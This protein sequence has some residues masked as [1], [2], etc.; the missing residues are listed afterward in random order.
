[1]TSKESFENI[2]CEFLEDMEETKSKVSSRTYTKS[3]GI[4]SKK[5]GCTVATTENNCL[6]CTGC[7]RPRA[8]NRHVAGLVN[9]HRFENNTLDTVLKEEEGT[10]TI[11]PASIVL[12][13]YVYEQGQ[14]ASNTLMRRGVGDELKALIPKAFETK[15]CGCQDYARKMNRWGV[16][17]CKKN[18]DEII[19]RLVKK[20]KETKVFGWV[21]DNATRFVAKRLLEMAIAKAEKGSYKSVTETTNKNFEWFVAVTTSPRQECTLR[22]CVESLYL[23]G[24]KPTIFAEPGSTIIKGCQTI[25]NK[26]RKGVWHNWLDSCKYALRNT[27]ADIIMTVQDDSLFHPDSKIFT[28]NILWPDKKTGF[29]SLYTP[30]H[31]SFK[32]KE[33]RKPGVNRIYTRSMWGACALVWPRE[34]LELVVEHPIAKNWLGAPTKSKS[35][36]IK[37]K[38][39]ENPY[40]IQ[41]SDTAIGKI[42]NS[43]KR[44]M[45][46][47]DPSPVQHFSRHSAINHG[48]NLG[49]RNC[50]RCADWETPLAGQ[51]LVDFKPV[52]IKT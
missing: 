50:H 2:N 36:K 3:C 38:R 37:Q 40:M 17:G 7:K 26:T 49:K 28:E 44:K 33:M 41:N 42:M 45:F 25:T 43:L 21:P 23:A 34:V 35:A 8:Y 12:P 52:K 30:K 13:Q 9:L 16:S 24:F 18:M 14:A 31:Y 6:A 46:F 11:D 5:A 32:G 1:M 4:A 10:L 48:N 22:K 47:V 39:K 19:D 51:V 20:S 27:D 29:V 15:G